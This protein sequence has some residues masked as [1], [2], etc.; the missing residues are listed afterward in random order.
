MVVVHLLKIFLAGQNPAEQVASLC[1]TLDSPTYIGIPNYIKLAFS[2]KTSEIGANLKYFKFLFF[3]YPF[4]RY[5]QISVTIKK[6]SKLFRR[7]SFNL[8]SKH[9]LPIYKI[10]NLPDLQEIMV[11]E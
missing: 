9:S 6:R 8:S 1:S 2:G 5:L 10:Y 7:I 3:F 11:L 4:T